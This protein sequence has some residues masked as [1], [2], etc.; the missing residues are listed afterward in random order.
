MTPESFAGRHPSL[1]RI[2]AEG[3]AEGIRRHG[4]LTA[5]QIAALTGLPPFT[6][7]RRRAVRATLP[8]GTAVAITDNAPLSF[9]RLAPVL[10]DGLRPAD[11]L[12]ML[13]GRVFFWVRRE[14][15]EANLRARRKLGYRSEWHRFDTLAL[16]APVWDRVEIAAINTGATVHQPPRRGR[17]TFAPLAGLDYEAWRERRRT[18]GVKKGLDSVQEVTVRDGVPHAGAAL[19][20][21][22]A[23]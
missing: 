7:P 18:A 16:L 23:A 17:A 19:R 15:G 21:V 6:A 2:S 1:W 12:G 9:A 4:L 20:E 11:W 3:S 10:D 22:I 8:D 14:A 13:D 5:A